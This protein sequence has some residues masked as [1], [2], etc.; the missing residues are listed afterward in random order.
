MVRYSITS[1]TDTGVF[2][3]IISNGKLSSVP[4]DEKFKVIMSDAITDSIENFST[5]GLVTYAQVIESDQINEFPTRRRRSK[6]SKV[7]ETTNSES[8]ES[9]ED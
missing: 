7:E 3:D 9:K 5:L 6:S 1:R 2:I 8:D 4:L